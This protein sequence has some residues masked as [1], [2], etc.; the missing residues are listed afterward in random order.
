MSYRQ[1]F[2]IHTTFSPDAESRPEEVL[3][4][5]EAQGLCEIM[6]T[7]HCDCDN[8]CAIPAP[9][10]AWPRLDLKQYTEK[11]ESLR[12][13]T[14]IRV[15]VGIELGEA[16]QMPEYSAEVLSFYDWDYVIGSFHNPKGKID[17]YYTDYTA[18]DL[19]TVFDEYFEGVYRLAVDNRFDVLGHLYYLV[20]YIY[21]QGLTADLSGYR[22]KIEEILR[23]LVRNGKGIEVNTSCLKDR[24]SG[25]IPGYDVIKMFKDCGGEIITVGSDAHTPERVGEGFDEALEAIREAGFTALA[26]FEK[27]N[28]VFRDI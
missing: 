4:A 21:R 23:V 20:R 19:R 9:L 26:S 28:P 12:S 13:M 2:H 22:G 16:D 10:E 7:D 17:Y 24:F 25:L 18:L 11:I 6:I 27:R 3:R 15:G 5:A 14:D 1:D 8:G